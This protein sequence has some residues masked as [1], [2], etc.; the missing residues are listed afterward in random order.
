M[1]EFLSVVNFLTKS[2]G[3]VESRHPHHP[4]SRVGS[5]IFDDFISPFANL[6]SSYGEVSGVAPTSITSR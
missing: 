6:K 4:N 5:T 3:F 2:Q 1:N